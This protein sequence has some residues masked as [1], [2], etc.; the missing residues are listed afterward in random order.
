VAF[1]HV[2]AVHAQQH[3][4]TLDVTISGEVIH[5]TTEHPFYVPDQGWVAAGALAIGGAVLRADGTPGTVESLVVIAAPQ[6]MYNLSVAH[7]ATYLV[8]EQRWVVQLQRGY[9]GR[10]GGRPQQSHRVRA[11]RWSKVNVRNRPVF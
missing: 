6:V 10:P 9:P 7:V 2:T 4:T 8:G 5:T 3:A 1:F 11:K